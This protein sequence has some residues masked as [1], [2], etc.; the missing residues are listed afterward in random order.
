[1]ETR[2]PDRSY[3]R[4]DRPTLINRRSQWASMQPETADTEYVQITE[5]TDERIDL[6]HTDLDVEYVGMPRRQVGGI[7]LRGGETDARRMDLLGTEVDGAVYAWSHSFD[8]L[9]DVSRSTSDRL[10]LRSSDGNGIRG[11]G[12]QTDRID[13]SRADWEDIDL[14]GAEVG[15]LRIEDADVDRIDLSGASIDSISADQDYGFIV[16][17]ETEIG[18]VPDH[19]EG[20]RAYERTTEIERELLYAVE[21]DS[22]DTLL[23]DATYRGAI[24]SLRSKGLLSE[25]RALSSE[26]V[27]LL[28]YLRD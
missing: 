24:G 7:D 9:L 22:T 20:L 15:E 6:R 5:D 26:G 4:T 25:D 23:E 17:P 3:R 8:A 14:S 11:Q 28:G 1:M 13:L 21:E 2:N 18:A 12:L 19:L 27:E 10:Y 16:D